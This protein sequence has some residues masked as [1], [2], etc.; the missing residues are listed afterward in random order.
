LSKTLKQIHRWNKVSLPS[1]L[2][3]PD[4]NVNRTSPAN[5]LRK[6]KKPAKHDIIAKEEAEEGFKKLTWISMFTDKTLR[7]RSLIMMVNWGMVALVYYGIGMSLTLVGGDIFINF[8]MGAIAEMCGYF[9]NIAV[10]DFWGR[11]P[12][13]V[14]GYINYLKKYA[15]LFYYTKDLHLICRF[16]IS[17]ICCVLAGV[18]PSGSSEIETL[19]LALLL[20]GK[21]G[22]SGA[23][24]VCYVYTSELF[25]TP[26]RNTAVGTWYV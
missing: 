1:N 6:K 14:T 26:I 3:I 10:S 12:T 21:L 16:L 20:L 9:F 11:K 2:I 22:C 7:S 19:R 24:A 23:F 5:L 13:M 25:P 15:I 4:D 8:I 18:I 17:G